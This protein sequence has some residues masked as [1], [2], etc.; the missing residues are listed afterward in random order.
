M[1]KWSIWICQVPCNYNYPEHLIVE[2]ETLEDAKKIVCAERFDGHDPWDFHWTFQNQKCGE[3]KEPERPKGR[4]V[5][6]ERP[7][8]PAS[9]WPVKVTS[10]R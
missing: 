10:L 2:A 6:T 1:K 4:I 5:R 8:P 7:S 3:Y 9:N